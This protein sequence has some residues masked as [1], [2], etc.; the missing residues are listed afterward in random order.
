[1]ANQVSRLKKEILIDPQDVK[2]ENL[3]KIESHHF[4]SFSLDYP[5]NSMWQSMV[6]FPNKLQKLSPVVMNPYLDTLMSQIHTDNTNV[7]ASL[8]TIFNSYVGNVYTHVDKRFKYHF[9][10]YTDALPEGMVRNLYADLDFFALPTLLPYTSADGKLL[11]SCGVF[12]GTDELQSLSLNFGWL[13]TPWQQQA[14]L[15]RRQAYVQLRKSIKAYRKQKMLPIDRK[16][17]RLTLSEV[18]GLFTDYSPEMSQWN[19]YTLRH[20][21]QTK[22]MSETDYRLITKMWADYH[23]KLKSYYNDAEIVK[24]RSLNKEYYWIPHRF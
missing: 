15:S 22:K 11:G 8:E 7:V 16:A 6:L 13:G 21:K 23:T 2:A 1:M 4:Q 9:G 20:L 24:Y 18:T 12:V 10:D 14:S 19:Q 17:K 3:F 5:K